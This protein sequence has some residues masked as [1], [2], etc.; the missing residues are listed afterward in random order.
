MLDIPINV[1][2]VDSKTL[3]GERFIEIRLYDKMIPSDI[4]LLVELIRSYFVP[5][6]I[7]KL[8]EVVQ[9]IRVFFSSRSYAAKVEKTISSF[10]CDIVMNILGD[11]KKTNVSLQVLDNIEMRD[12]H[13]WEHDA[14]LELE[15]IL[16]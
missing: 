4:I 16:C 11:R 2:I 8:E 9:D 1:W 6:Q 15:H 10:N 7:I 12:I 13:I 3:V 5:T 14:I